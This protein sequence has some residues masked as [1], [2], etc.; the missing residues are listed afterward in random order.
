L[1]KEDVGIPNPIKTDDLERLARGFL[2]NDLNED[3]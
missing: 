3:R 2:R 1:E